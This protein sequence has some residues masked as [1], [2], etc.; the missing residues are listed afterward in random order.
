MPARPEG[1]S[2]ENR[3]EGSKR[4][5]DGLFPLFNTIKIYIESHI[6]HKLKKPILTG[7]PHL[8]VG[9]SGGPDSIFLLYFLKHLADE[10]KVTI[11]AAHLNHGWRESAG[12]DEQFC[13]DLCENLGISIVVSHAK[14]LTVILKENGS[15]EETG[16]KLRRH[17]FN[18]VRLERKADYIAL[19]H[20]Q[21]DQ[22]ETFFMRLIR[23]CSLSGLTGIKPVQN[24]YVRP[25][26]KTPKK[27]I[28][29]F[30]DENK[31]T[32]Q[33]DPTNLSEKFLRNRI[34]MHLLPALQKCDPRFDQKFEHSLEQLQEEDDFLQ[35]LA[36]EAFETVFDHELCGD[37]K[38]FES[39]ETT[40]QK[41]LLIMWLNKNQVSYT[42]ST[43]FLN[44]MI[45]F[46][47]SDR[48]GSHQLGQHWSIRKRQNVFWIET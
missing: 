23:G 24:L 25:L 15:Q 26:L 6:D 38:K 17:F 22:Q 11:T 10:K 3:L 42:P 48:G 44:E 40:L 20:H 7:K 45:R 28:L 14:N 43:S 27:E 33:I 9:L 46:V 8:V 16:R 39:L 12:D 30:L 32:Y 1:F 5:G 35:K 29:Q 41:H 13:R 36:H 21:Q 2:L 19:A 34:R 4:S 31:I 37:K 47:A 18:K